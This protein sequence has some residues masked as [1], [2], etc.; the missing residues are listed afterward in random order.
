MNANK[1][2]VAALVS[3]LFGLL[4]YFV[5]VPDEIAIPATAVI[6]GAATWAIPN[7]PK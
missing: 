2:W 7:K 3:G 6:T 4:R 1:A 5:N